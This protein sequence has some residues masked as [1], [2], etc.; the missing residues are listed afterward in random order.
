[1]NSEQ[2]A[3]FQS[4]LAHPDDDAPRLIYADWLEEHNDT[5]RAE[6]IRVQIGLARDECQSP[7]WRKLVFRARKLYNYRWSKPMHGKVIHCEFARGFVDRITIFSKRFAETAEKLFEIEPIQVLKLANLQ[8]ARGNIPVAE[9]A[10][11]PSL[12]RLRGL[13]L[14]LCSEAPTTVA[15]LGA[16]GHLQQLK[17]LTVHPA[18]FS[19]KQVLAS[20]QAAQINTLETLRTGHVNSDYPMFARPEWT[21]FDFAQLAKWPGVRTLKTL[22]LHDVA[23][24]PALLEAFCAIPFQQLETLDLTGQHF[25]HT[26]HHFFQGSQDS[27]IGSEGLKMLAHAPHLGTL[28]ELSARGH[29]ITTTGIKALVQAPRMKNL[30]RLRLSGNP[31]DLEGIQAFLGDTVFEKM[32]LLDIDYSDTPQREEEDKKALKKRYPE[33]ALQPIAF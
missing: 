11:C 8:A 18:F 3:L 10:R 33:A 27:G 17:E 20:L 12:A 25:I 15:D 16:E 22:A 5:I 29:G 26:S 19:G 24:T 7:K 23:W 30:R 4:I 14:S 28:K 6:F 21:A 9:L 31:I 13:D 32:Y 1:M 2:R